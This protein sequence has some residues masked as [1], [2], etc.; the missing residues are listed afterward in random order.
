MTHKTVPTENHVVQYARYYVVLEDMRHNPMPNV[1]FGFLVKL[2]IQHHLFEGFFFLKT[3][4][5]LHLNWVSNG[6]RTE[7][8]FTA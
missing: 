2:A 1:L 7:I 5:F 8:Q 4:S 6:T 3:I